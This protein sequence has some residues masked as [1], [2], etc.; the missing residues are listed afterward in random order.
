MDRRPCPVPNAGGGQRENEEVVVSAAFDVRMARCVGAACSR[1]CQGGSRGAPGGIL[2]LTYLDL[3]IITPSFIRRLQIGM[4]CL[5]VPPLETPASVV[6]AS[7]LG[8]ALGWVLVS[9]VLS[10]GSGSEL[11]GRGV[12]TA[13]LMGGDEESLVIGPGAPWHSKGMLREL[14]LGSAE[15]RSGREDGD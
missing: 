5:W 14:A 1:G 9:R 2:S 12:T 3:P 6:S 4:S 7:C 11:G 10:P 13:R 15:L 8:P